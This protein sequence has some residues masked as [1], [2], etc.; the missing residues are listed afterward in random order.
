MDFI[1]ELFL[2]DIFTINIIH[3]SLRELLKQTSALHVEAAAYL[4]HIAEPHV[5]HHLHIYTEEPAGIV[6]RMHLGVYYDRIE[7]WCKAGHLDP[8]VCNWIMVRMLQGILWV[9]CIC[10]LSA[11]PSRIAGHHSWPQQS[12]CM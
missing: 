1:G 3:L 5:E 7:G 11:W 10:L 8:E 6:G 4:L 12:I 9:V 2:S